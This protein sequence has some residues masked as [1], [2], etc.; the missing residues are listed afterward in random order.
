M[1]QYRAEEHSPES[2]FWTWFN[3]HQSTYAQLDPTNLEDWFATLGE[4]LS[5]IDEDLVFELSSAPEHGKHMLVISGDGMRRA[6]PAVV[7]LVD[8]A[9]DLPDWEIVAFRQPNQMDAF[10]VDIADFRLTPG[11]VKFSFTPIEAGLELHLY[12]HNYDRNQ[13]HHY[14]ACM[15]LLESLLGENDVAT[16]IQYHDMG[17]LSEAEEPDSLPAIEILPV[18]IEDMRQGRL[19]GSVPLFPSGEIQYTDPQAIPREFVMM[20]ALEHQKPNMV[21]INPHYFEFAPK[22]DYPWL[23]IVHL[24]YEPS[25]TEG[26]PDGPHLDQLNALEK[27][28][29]QHLSEVT[30]ALF[31]YRS[32]WNGSRQIYLH[33]SNWKVARRP[34]TDWIERH[35]DAQP[36]YE[37]F[38]EKDWETV[39]AMLYHLHHADKDHL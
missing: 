39:R 5:E 14:L 20:Q 28:L 8:A 29:I 38:Y 21:L 4:K 27:K 32:T 23:L 11:D 34:L 1:G 37:I 9:P 17:T 30:E 7:S 19:E 36:T 26:L 13:P 15:I 31:V 33:L 24:A 10:S 6:F 3:S 25:T 2:R 35:T 12:I 16:K 18:L 22:A